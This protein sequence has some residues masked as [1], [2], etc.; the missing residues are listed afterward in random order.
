MGRE[1]APQKTLRAS[2]RRG[3]VSFMTAIC[4]APDTAALPQCTSHKTIHNSA[5]P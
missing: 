4:H 2:M 5:P 3:H 1:E